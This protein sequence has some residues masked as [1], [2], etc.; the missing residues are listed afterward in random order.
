MSGSIGR[1]AYQLAFE[2]SPIVF[3]N[4]IAQNVPGQ[5][6]PVV[7]ITEAASFIGGILSGGTTPSL[8]QFFAHFFP[9][10]GATLAEWQIG[11]YPFANQAVAANALI[12]QPLTLS[13]LMRCPPQPGSGGWPSKL[14]TMTALQLAIAQHNASGGTFIVITPSYFYTNMILTAFRDISHKT[15]GNPQ[16]DWQWDFEQPLLTL[17]QAQS[18]QSSLMSKLSSGTSIDG[19][20]SWTGLSTTLGNPNTV[21]SPGLIPA[22]GG[23]AG[24]LTAPN[25][26]GFGS[27][28]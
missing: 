18:V 1:Q 27:G 25:S 13:M 7:V 10:P 8:D 14:V 16:D 9:L 17:N 12:A 26:T 23:N 11:K 19:Q 3:V 6:L 5:M 28:P 4:G 22:A 15:G 20:P 21:Q 2:C 24:P